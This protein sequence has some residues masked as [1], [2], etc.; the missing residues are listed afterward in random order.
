MKKIPDYLITDVRSLRKTLESDGIEQKT[1]GLQ[2]ERLTEVLEDESNNLDVH[3]FVIETV[4]IPFYPVILA[5][6]R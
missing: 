5:N 1:L 2:L 6:D 3:L 4:I